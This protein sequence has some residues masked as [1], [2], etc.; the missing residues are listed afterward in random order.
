MSKE[1]K[2][3]NQ[4]FPAIKNVIF[5]W[6][7]TLYDPETKTLI[8]GATEIL[9]MFSNKNIPIF[10]IGKGEEEMHQEVNRLGIEKFFT[11]VKFAQ[12]EKNPE[13]FKKYIDPFNPSETFIIGDRALS[14]LS[15]GKSLMASTV[16]VRQGVYADELPEAKNLTPDYQVRSLA[17]LKDLV[18]KFL[19]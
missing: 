6:K 8:N 5:D 4:N 11:G 17:E 12:G 1:N 10:L 13:D 14:E 7:R 19:M 16:W 15:V 3:V 2:E 9:E 18:E